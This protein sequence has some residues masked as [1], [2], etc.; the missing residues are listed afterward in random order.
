[1]NKTNNHQPIV[2]IIIP[3]YNGSNYV[4][5]AIDSA[6]AQTYKNI[7]VIVVNDGSNDGGKTEEIALS[8]GDKIKY[9]KKENG[10]VSSALNLGIKKMQGEYFSWLSHDDKYES[11]KIEEQINLIDGKSDVIALCSDAKINKNSIILGNKSERRFPE[12]MRVDSKD[13][14]KN[15]LEKGSF[16]GC[17]LLI[18]KV[19]IEKAGG[20]DETLRYVQDVLMWIKIFLQG[21]SV[22]YSYKVLCYCRV[23]DAQ[24]T[25]TGREVFHKESLEMVKNITEDLKKSSD[26]RYN[27]LYFL[28]KHNATIGNKAV[29]KYVLE[30]NKSSKS[31][32]FMQRNNIRFYGLYGSIRPIIRK[33]YYKLF[34][35][36]K[37]Q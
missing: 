26:I 35:R 32:S 6:L 18:P 8:Y 33:L 28:A 16:N 25:Q 7:E 17:A 5:E 36:V 34:L 30:F 11:G 12:N 13:V 20:F 15:I 31:L 24:L 37:T 10:G 4:K 22:I 2:S 29:A 1:M 9:F 14:L 27:F 21:Y 19:A 23:H 3:V